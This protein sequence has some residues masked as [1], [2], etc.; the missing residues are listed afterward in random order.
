MSKEDKK[1]DYPLSPTPK[2]AT[3]PVYR[4]ENKGA[5]YQDSMIAYNSIKGKSAGAE[6]LKPVGPPKQYIGDIKTSSIK[7]KK[8]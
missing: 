3:T 7:V 8:K 6:K 1:R 5:S 2:V 4:M